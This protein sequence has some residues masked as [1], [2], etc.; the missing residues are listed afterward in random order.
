MV[1][2]TTLQLPLPPERVMVQFT[3]APVTAT[4]PVGVTPPPVTLKLTKTACP[5]LDGSGVSAVM[6]VEVEAWLTVW[7]ALVELG[8]K[9]PSPL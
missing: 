4:V 7:L 3:S 5:G 8:A 1:L 2:K 6:V 9:F